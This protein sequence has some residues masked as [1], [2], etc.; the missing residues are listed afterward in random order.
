M[1]HGLNLGGAQADVQHGSRIAPEAAELSHL[2]RAIHEKGDSSD[3]VFKGRL[4]RKGNRQADNAEPGEK[5]YKRNSEMRSSVEKNSHA[6]GDAEKT[7]GGPD[8]ACVHAP[9]LKS[10][11]EE[12][13]GREKLSHPHDDPRSSYPEQGAEKGDQQGVEGSGNVY[14]GVHQVDHE[15]RSQ[16]EH[17]GRGYAQELR[18]NAPA[19]LGEKSAETPGS[20]QEKNKE[21]K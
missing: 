3:D 8:K 16:G 12:N 11:R 14:L 7:V 17:Q 13:E 9:L 20:H 1:I 6:G 21:K 2:Y 10:G 19:S 18:K 5:S 4:C 15:V